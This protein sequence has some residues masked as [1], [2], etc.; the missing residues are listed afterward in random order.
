MIYLEDYLDT[1]EA[2]PI[3][4]QRN[5]SLLRELD[6]S[7]QGVLDEL[8]KQTKQFFDT[9][10][11]ATAE[12]RM[13]SLRKLSSMF[14]QCLKY[15]EDKVALATQTYDMVDRHVQRADDDLQRFEEDMNQGPKQYK[16]ISLRREKKAVPS[17]ASIKEKRSA[18]VTSDNTPNKKRR[19][20][21]TPPDTKTPMNKDKASAATAMRMMTGSSADPPKNPGPRKRD[22]GSNKPKPKKSNEAVDFQVLNEDMKIDP[23][24][25]K[26]CYCG[27]VSYGEMVGCDGDDCPIEWF[28][29]GCLNLKVPPKGKW[30]CDYCKKKVKK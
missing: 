27:H 20:E 29:L 22:N 5:F 26:Y 30:Y 13:E 15:G 6:A 24:E 9:L 12:E 7:A 2:L 17:N 16:E 3:E 19:K 8:E 18:P 23:N 25:P 1:I 21:S 11:T 28:H 4:L 10:E 14:Q